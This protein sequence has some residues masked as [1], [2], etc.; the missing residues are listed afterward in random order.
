MGLFGKKEKATFYKFLVV[1]G[2]VPSMSAPST[3]R[4]SLLPDQIEIR[5]IIG[6][7]AVAYLSYSQVTAAAKIGER[8]IV[9]TDKSV[10]GRAMVGGVMLGPLGAV[11]GGMSGVGK[12]QKTVYKDFFVINYTA[13]SGEPSV[14]SFEMVGPPVGFAP[15]L[16]ELK[17]RAGI[18]EAPAQEGPTFL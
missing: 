8:E 7:K 5:Q 2:C 11:V 17:Q 1:D 10:I 6:G 13:A 18:V 3:V 9:E 4:I 14:L 16:S 12:K 15:F